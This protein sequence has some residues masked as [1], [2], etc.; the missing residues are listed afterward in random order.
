MLES[1]AHM[2]IQE[3]WWLGGEPL[4]H[5]DLFNLIS[6]GYKKGISRHFVFTNGLLLN[7]V[8]SCKQLIKNKCHVVFHIDTINPNDFAFL[9]SSVP[10]NSDCIWN[11]VHTQMLTG[12]DNL[13]RQGFPSFFIRHNITLTRPILKHL[14]ETMR[15]SISEKRFSMITLVPVFSCGRGT[16]VNP[17]DYLSTDEIYAAFKLRAS[18]EK[19]PWLMELGP[20]EYCKQYQLTT[21]YITVDGNVLPYAGIDNVYGNICN[22]RFENI[23]K[24][25]AE[26][27][28]FHDLQHGDMKNK[29]EG[30]CGK[31]DKE[32]YCF[33]TR[34]VAFRNGKGLTD[35][36]P[37]CWQYRI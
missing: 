35:S 28:F 36:D 20:S 17:N 34:T 27:L 5:P 6:F 16:K 13:L 30:Y 7:N 14:S 22:D 29:L 32:E 21:C 19:R 12:I 24:K 11:T 4:L 31:C 2:G 9:H 1:A 15:W 33:G 3:V 37:S 25:N 10:A 18:V 26:K 23:V 8:D